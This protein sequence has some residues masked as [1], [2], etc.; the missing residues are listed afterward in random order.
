MISKIAFSKTSRTY[1]EDFET[2]DER[3]ILRERKKKNT[4]NSDVMDDDRQNDTE[5]FVYHDLWYTFFF[6]QLLVI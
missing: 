6:S 3:M 5:Q 2:P 1:S 4:L